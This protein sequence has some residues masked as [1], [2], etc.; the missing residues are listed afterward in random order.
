VEAHGGD[1]PS[2]FATVPGIPTKVAAFGSDAPRLT[3]FQT[4]CLCGPGSILVAHTPKEYV[5][6]SDLQKATAQYI[7]MFEHFAAPSSDSPT[8]WELLPFS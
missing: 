5:L 2:K 1:A 3:K 8:L 4:R 6:L 7:K